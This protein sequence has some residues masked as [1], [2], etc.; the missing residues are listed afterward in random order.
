MLK[1]LKGRGRWGRQIIMNLVTWRSVGIFESGFSAVAKM[2]TRGGEKV[3]QAVIDP[4]KN[5]AV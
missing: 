2:R 3:H 5:F 1:V 4:Y